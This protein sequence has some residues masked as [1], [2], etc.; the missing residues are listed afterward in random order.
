MQ[1]RPPSLGNGKN[2]P[3]EGIKG[4]GGEEVPKGGESWLAVEKVPG[5]VQR[6]SRNSGEYGRWEGRV[7]FGCFDRSLLGGQRE[8]PARQGSVGK[9]LRWFLPATGPLPSSLRPSGLSRLA[10]GSTPGAGQVEGPAGAGA[11]AAARTVLE[12]LWLGQRRQLER[13]GGGYRAGPS[14]RLE[15]PV[16]LLPGVGEE[17]AG[18]SVSNPVI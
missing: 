13:L 9:G 16:Y 5:G 10:G 14:S 2:V 6:A 17:P 3:V 1:V 18:W 7:R 4:V 11:E 8:R 12:P 15:E